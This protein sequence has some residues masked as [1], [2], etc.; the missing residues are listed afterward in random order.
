MGITSAL[1]MSFWQD[2]K[3]GLRMLAREPGFTAVMVTALALG[4]GVNTTVFTLVN[5]VLF[6]GLP[7]DHAERVMYVSSHRASDPDH[8]LDVSY[9]DFRDWRTQ[10][11]SFEGFAAFRGRGMTLADDSGAPERFLGPEVSSNFFSLIGQAPM[12]GRDFLPEEDRP[13][14]TP[15][16]ILGYST[17]EGGYGSRAD[18]LG[19]TIRVNQVPTTVIGVMPKGMKFP[20]NGDIWIPLVPKGDWEKRDFREMGAFGRLKAG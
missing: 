8:D 7:F 5:A 3:Y 15:V 12:L 10:S 6:R 2:V 11:K 16:C 1:N 4:I 13:G 20:L 9:P 17:W 14:A 19:K 18:V